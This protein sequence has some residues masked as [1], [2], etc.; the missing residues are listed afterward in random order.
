MNVYKKD[1]ENCKIAKNNILLVAVRFEKKSLLIL[2][3]IIAGINIKI[4]FDNSG[5]LSKLAI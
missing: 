1:L 3:K 5:E 4:A 2:K